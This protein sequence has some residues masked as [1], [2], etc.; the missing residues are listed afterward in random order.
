MV[1]H[2]PRFVSHRLPILGPGLP[3]WVSP[4]N[5]TTANSRPVELVW[6]AEV[7]G[8][9]RGGNACNA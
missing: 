3:M 7:A 5:R 1:S 2:S 8:M 4:G 9:L 6:G